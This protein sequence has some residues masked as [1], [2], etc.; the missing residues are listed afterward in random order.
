LKFGTRSA[1][2]HVYGEQWLGSVFLTACFDSKAALSS[3]VSIY[4]QP[5][6]APTRHS[7]LGP[8]SR[9]YPACE[10]Q[11]RRL[12]LWL[13]LINTGLCK[14]CPSWCQVKQELSLNLGLGKDGKRTQ[15]R[16]LELGLTWLQQYKTF[17]YSPGHTFQTRCHL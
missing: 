6:A 11:L 15:V 8:C 9:T 12:P 2:T 7:D 16:T 10:A 3:P 13:V 4:D 17:A 5:L 1:E 14:E